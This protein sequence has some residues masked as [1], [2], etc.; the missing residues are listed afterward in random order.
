MEAG[1]SVSPGQWRKNGSPD[2]KADLLAFPKGALVWFREEGHLSEPRRNCSYL[3]SPNGTNDLS[4]PEATALDG[5]WAG[6]HLL[7][8][9]TLP[10]FLRCLVF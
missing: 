3:E 6:Y 1:W 9:M 8:L 5:T 2:S 7:R 4:P 10:L